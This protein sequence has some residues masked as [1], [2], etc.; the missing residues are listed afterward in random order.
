M[1]QHRKVIDSSQ[2]VYVVIATSPPCSQWSH[3]AS[4]CLACSIRY[5]AG[6]SPYDIMLAF[7]ISYREVLN[8]VWTIVEAI[9]EEEHHG[10][11]KIYLLDL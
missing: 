2:K 3:L 6:G 8:S 5:F 7:G 9:N 10:G 11:G 4:S 1:K